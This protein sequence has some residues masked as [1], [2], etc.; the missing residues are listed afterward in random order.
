MLSII[1][2]RTRQS[3]DHRIIGDFARTL[4]YVGL[5]VLMPAVVVV[6]VAGV[7]LVLISSEWNFT[8]LWVLLGLGAFGIAFLIG[9]MQ[10]RDPA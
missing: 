10:G 3:E 6:L 4:S 5:R 2:A 1:G 9:A 7:W 8:Q